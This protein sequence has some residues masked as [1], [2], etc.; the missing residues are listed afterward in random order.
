MVLVDADTGIEADPVVV[1]R[2]TGRRL[3]GLDFVFTA[4]AAASSAFTNRYEHTTPLTA[5]ASTH[6]Y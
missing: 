2:A 1:D 3:D 6:R 4:G 5:P